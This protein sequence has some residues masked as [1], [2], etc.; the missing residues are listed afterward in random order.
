MRSW[1]YAYHVGKDGLRITFSWG[2]LRPEMEDVV[3][4]PHSDGIRP[5]LKYLRARNPEY[6]W[7]SETDGYGGW[8]ILERRLA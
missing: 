5:I 1:Q 7:K 8:H 3:H 4:F 6:E 2:F